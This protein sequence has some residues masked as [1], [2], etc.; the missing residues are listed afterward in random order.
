MFLPINTDLGKLHIVEVFDYFD[1]PRIFFCANGTGQQFLALWQ[2]NT[3]EGSEWL[4]VPMSSSRVS[5]VRSG[6]IDLHNAVRQVEDGFVY[7][8]NLDESDN[9]AIVARIRADELPD[10]DLA[11]TGVMLQSQATNTEYELKS[12]EHENDTELTLVDLRLFAS[13]FTD[14]QLDIAILALVL[15]GWSTML[16]AANVENAVKVLA[17]PEGSFILRLSVSGQESSK[18][19]DRILDILSGVDDDQALNNGETE[20]K[21]RSALSIFSRILLEKSLEVEITRSQTSTKNEP[22]VLRLDREEVRKILKKQSL[23]DEEA[24]R[25][26]R[27][28][29]KKM[30]ASDAQHP[31]EPNSGKLPYVRLT[32]GKGRGEDSPGSVT[33]Y[34]FRYD[35]FGDLSWSPEHDKRQNE[36]WMALFYASVVFDGKELG[37]QEFKVTYQEARGGHH[38]Q[39]T[40]WLH[41]NH[42]LLMMVKEK[43]YTGYW[44]CIRRDYH[45]RTQIS[46]A[47]TE[48][49][50]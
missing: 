21:I 36:R 44:I 4:Y 14:S 19:V 30:S 24:S 48:P 38:N 16:H 45:G 8:L 9:S 37:I 18:D 49:E 17:I 46:I 33:K 1:G 39:P 34:D 20:R 15:K 31:P 32:Q 40:T 35:F 47:R 2:G 12:L 43:D 10:E 42:R 7:H 11:D 26:D 3:P 6:M 5:T 23:T 27:S 28:W 29:K 22:R 50:D 13:E 41:W 25:F